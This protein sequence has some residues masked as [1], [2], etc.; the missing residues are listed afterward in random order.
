M[1]YGF[2]EV[3]SEAISTPMHQIEPLLWLGNQK[4]AS[5]LHLLRAHKISAIL[6]LL[7]KKPEP[8]F[9]GEFTYYAVDIMDSPTED[10]ISI[11]R[12]SL[13]F[14]ETHIRNGK[15]VLVH[16]QAGMSR[17]ASVV[18]AYLMAKYRISY[19][20]AFYTVRDR[21]ACISPNNGFAK[22]LCSMD[23][24]TLSEYINV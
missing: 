15:G 4:A 17:S 16:C 24:E 12:K 23:L 13:A 9:E 22:Q 7:D 3:Y 2:S 6:Q 14:I 10:I 5:D 8:L 1:L 11:I 20:E 19:E 21:R 18:I